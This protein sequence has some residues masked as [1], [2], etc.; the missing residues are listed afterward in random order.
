VIGPGRRW[1]AVDV[2]DPAARVSSHG[3]PWSDEGGGI[4]FVGA[5]GSIQLA[6]C[7]AGLDATQC[8]AAAPTGLLAAVR[9]AVQLRA[10]PVR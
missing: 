6:A 9:T 4:V 8:K 1:F 3:D 5:D 2:V 7:P 10:L